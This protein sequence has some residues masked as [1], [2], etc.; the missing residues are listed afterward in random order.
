MHVNMLRRYVTRAM[1]CNIEVSEENVDDS[2]SSNTDQTENWKDIQLNPELTATQKEQLKELLREFS[3]VFTDVPGR[4]DLIQHDFS[5]K[6]DVKPVQMK[7][8]R[9]PKALE[10]EVQTELTKMLKNGIISRTTSK[11]ASP[12]VLV[13][14]KDKT[15]R[16]C[17]NYRRLNEAM[18]ADP[19][20][21]PR[22]DEIL[23]RKG[24]AKYISSCD[25]S[26][27]YWQ[28]SISYEARVKSAFI[29]PVG[30]FCYNVILF[31]LKAAPQTFVRLM[32]I[33]LRGTEGYADAYF[34]D[35]SIFSNT[36]E[37]H[38]D[39]LRDVFM[40]IRRAKLTIRPSQC[41]LGFNEVPLVGHVVGNGHVKPQQEKV[42]AVVNFPQPI[43]TTVR[44]FLGLVGYY[45]KYIPNFA[46]ISAPLTDLTKKGKPTRIVWS[47]EC[48]EAML[49][50]KEHLTQEPVLTNPDFTK[51]LTLQTDASDKGLGAVLS[52]IDKTGNEKAVEFLSKKLL[53]REQAYSTI[54]KECLAI[55]W[56]CK[57]LRHY[58]FGRNFIISTDHQPLTWLNRMKGGNQ[59]LL[60]W[61]LELQQYDFEI[62]HKKGSSNGNADGLSR[63][64]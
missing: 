35:V 4:T 14:K 23:A 54:E 6:D 60:R 24:K 38:L 39:H 30:H 57:Y 2:I 44:S 18:D 32:D 49:T 62:K 27:G 29:T 9:I 51:Q 16:T 48:A 34:D 8:Y 37:G 33:V 21:I 17:V 22:M 63:A 26:K 3:D 64:W 1:F 5:V 59:R 40:Q 55:V 19:Y 31:G 10:K 46:S 56:A 43:T 13:R 42:S 47:R 58:L 41:N 36:W 52:Q 11:W 61:S 53:P 28:I 12:M 25:L 7:P 45:R 20:C 50:L 15:R